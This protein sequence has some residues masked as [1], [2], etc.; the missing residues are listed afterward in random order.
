MVIFI[1]LLPK[2]LSGEALSVWA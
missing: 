1:I 2:F